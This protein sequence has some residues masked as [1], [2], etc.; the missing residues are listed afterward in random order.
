[1][2]VCYCLCFTELAFNESLRLN[3]L[4]DVKNVENLTE[5]G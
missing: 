1:M 5:E 2:T 3:S 4:K